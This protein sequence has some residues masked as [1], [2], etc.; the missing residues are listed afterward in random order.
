MI[1]KS[2]SKINLS[3]KVNSKPGKGLHE[4]QS[5][6]CLINL[7]DKIKISKNQKPKDKIIF[8]GP[9][10]KFIKQKN[11]SV[12]ILIKKLR[13]LNLISN[14]YSIVITKNIPVFAGLGGGTGNAASLMKFFLKNKVNDDILK[15]LGVAIGSDFKLF[16]SKQG[17]LKNLKTIIKFKKKQKLY[18]VLAKPNVN[19][20]TKEIY[21]KVKKFSKKDKFNQNILKS[22]NKFLVYLA[23]NR[24]DLQFIV[25]KKHPQLKKLLSDI[26]HE[27]GCCFSRMTGSGSVCYGLFKY[28]INAKKALNKLKIKYPK[29]WLSLAK[30]V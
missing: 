7:I 24:N 8:K 9:F 28:K 4:I 11:N 29:F 12:H 14:Y 17:F 21:S 23:K 6:Y 30:T 27:K 3:L 20:S 15:K 25:E 26:N 18:F 2:Y 5:F 22:R 16:F 1:I 13:E 10:G 19:C